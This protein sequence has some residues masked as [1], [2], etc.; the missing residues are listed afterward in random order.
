MILQ[1]FPCEIIPS[2]EKSSAVKFSKANLLPE[3]FTRFRMVH[4]TVINFSQRPSEN[5][6]LTQPQKY[7][8][9][10]TWL[11]NSCC[12]GNVISRE[13]LDVI[14]NCCQIN[15]RKKSQ[16]LAPV[17]L[18]FKKKV[19]KRPHPHPHPNRQD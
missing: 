12:H 9:P 15:F 17:A 4:K 8:K 10:K 13:Q 1:V 7:P 16:G 11:S 6:K 3:I 14:Q 5:R 19:L 18:I 2:P